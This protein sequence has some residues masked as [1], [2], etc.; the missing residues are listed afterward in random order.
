VFPVAGVAQGDFDGLGERL[1]DGLGVFEGLAG[2]LGP[3]E[4]DGTGEPAP[5]LDGLALGACE[6]EAGAVDDAE[7]DGD[8]D[9]DGLGD[10]ST[11]TDGGGVG[12]WTSGA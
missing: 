11:N 12:R 7:A 1:G 10:G 9:G 8:G 5:L 2:A 6:G 4:P 3:T